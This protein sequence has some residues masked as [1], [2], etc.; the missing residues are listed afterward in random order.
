MLE[1]HL[2]HLPGKL[3]GFIYILV[4]LL[5]AALTLRSFVAFAESMFMYG[6]P[7]SILI[8]AALIPA[9]YMLRISLQV[10]AMVT[11]IIFLVSLPLL[12]LIILLALQNSDA[13]NLMPIGYVSLRDLATASTQSFWHL[14]NLA[15]ILTLAYYSKDRSKIPTTLFKTYIILIIA[16]FLS[17]IASIMHLGSDLASRLAFPIFTILRSVSIGFIQN[18]EVIFISLF[19]AG[20]SIGLAL[21]W[22][23]ACYTCQE[24]F[25]LKDYRPLLGPTAIIIGLFTVQVSPNSD[26]LYLIARN[27]APFLFGFFFIV[28]PLFLATVLLFK[29]SAG[30][31]Q[32]SGLQADD[33]SSD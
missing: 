9:F 32:G 29:P 25:K 26:I 23:M 30:T 3:L 21:Y 18:I 6:F 12:L 31:Y 8:I 5:A 20:T 16:G 28:I 7:V 10:Y 27:V 22:F 1:D 24:V 19:L 13:T 15:I 11:E 17:V 33:S 4:F 2:G 14:S